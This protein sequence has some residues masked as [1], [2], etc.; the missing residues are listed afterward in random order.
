MKKK[1]LKKFYVLNWDFNSDNIY[2][3]DVLP[4]LRNRYE[5]QVKSW[6]N[7]QKSKR[8]QNSIEKG[9]ITEHDIEKYYKAPENWNELRDFIDNES[10]HQ[11]WAR[12]EY[13]MICHGWPVKDNDYKIDIYEQI[14]MNLDII[15]D[16][17]YNEYF[18]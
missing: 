10:R 15:T 6:K 17:L 12:C 5:E 16:I 2:H 7:K 13:E 4:Y 9:F 14:K 11:F 1:E 8:F 3:Y 18:K